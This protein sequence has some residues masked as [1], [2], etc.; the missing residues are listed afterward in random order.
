VELPAL[1]Q[2]HG[3]QIRFN[4]CFGRIILDNVVQGDWRRSVPAPAW[5]NLS[6]AQ[7]AQAIAIAESVAKDATGRALYELDR[8][9]HLWRG[10]SLK[11]RHLL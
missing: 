1:A 9:S 4:H 8:K 6:T 10:K 7:L 5:A 3:W 11:R 2:Q